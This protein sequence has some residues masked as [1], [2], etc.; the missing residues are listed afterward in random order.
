VVEAVVRME[1]LRMTKEVVVAVVLVGIVNL[2]LK[3]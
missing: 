2:L 3:H 1:I